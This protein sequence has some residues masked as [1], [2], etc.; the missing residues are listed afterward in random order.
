MDT[1]YE[2]TIYYEILYIISFSGFLSLQA[3]T[4][5]SLG[6]CT[7]AN[8]TTP[9]YYPTNLIHPTCN[10]C[11]KC[12]GI[13]NPIVIIAFLTPYI[14]RYSICN[15]GSSRILLLLSWCISFIIIIIT[16]SVY[17]MKDSMALV[18]LVYIINAILLYT[19]E[20]RSRS[21]YVHYILTLY[22]L[23]AMCI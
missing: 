11:A 15:S 6:D 22:L 1:C 4:I 21:W 17:D 16:I 19:L 10:I 20:K 2:Y 13:Y 3:L 5:A 23:Y 14:I 9:I 8:T 18:P 7:L 12:H